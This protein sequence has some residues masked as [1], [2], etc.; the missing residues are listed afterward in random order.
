MQN[1]SAGETGPSGK[2][3][4]Q[5]M[6]AL[7]DEAG[8]GPRSP[9]PVCGRHSPTVYLA[10]RGALGVVDNA[11][12]SAEGNTTRPNIQ[13]QSYADNNINDLTYTTNSANS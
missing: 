2:Q 1:H 9:G 12:T 6:Q 11:A 4:R 7:Q 8:T 10:A 5:F 3:Y 13:P